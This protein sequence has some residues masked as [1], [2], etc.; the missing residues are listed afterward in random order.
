[1]RFFT[2]SINVM[3]LRAHFAPSLD[4]AGVCLAATTSHDSSENN[5]LGASRMKCLESL[6]SLL[7]SG[8]MRKEEEIG[9][10]VG[11]AL[12]Q[13]AGCYNIQVQSTVWGEGYDEEF[14]NQLSP[15]EHALYF[16]LRKQYRLSNPLHRTASAP[17]LLGIIAMVAREVSISD[18]VEGKKNDWFSS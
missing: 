4:K 7:G 6:M 15:H 9:L 13:Y 11:E 16:L 12:A 18:F 3:S 5:K 10:Y 14:A 2:R 1:M 8:V 17:A